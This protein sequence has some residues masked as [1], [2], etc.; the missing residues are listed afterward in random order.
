MKS[1]VF[2]INSDADVC[3]TTN[4]LKDAIQFLDG[5]PEFNMEDTSSMWIEKNKEDEELETIIT[6]YGHNGHARFYRDGEVW[7][8]WF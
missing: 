2:K 6:K 4:L 5:H 8:E 7:N 3:V 1:F